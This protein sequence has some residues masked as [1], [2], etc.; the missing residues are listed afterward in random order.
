MEN[1]K[2]LKVTDLEG[3]IMPSQPPIPI[4]VCNLE[5]GKSFILYSVPY[6]VITAL[7]EVKGPTGRSSIFD[8]LVTFARELEESI[9]RKIKKVVIDTFD[10]G[11]MVYGA[12]VYIDTGGATIV[13]K[14]IP[15]HAIFLA[16]LLN[17]P[18]Y[19]TEELVTI[20]ESIFEE[21]SGE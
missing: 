11:Y 10:P 16:H 2:L 13:K 18:I 4:L 1:Q 17:R 7:N 12:S 19:V 21:K 8:L 9:G 20:Q 6:E 3:Y 14:V 15:S 5:N